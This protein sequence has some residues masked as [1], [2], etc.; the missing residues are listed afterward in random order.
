[1]EQIEFGV[2]RL[3]FAFFQFAKRKKI[4]ENIGEVADRR[5]YAGGVFEAFFVL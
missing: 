2:L 3:D 4:I 5:L 1:M